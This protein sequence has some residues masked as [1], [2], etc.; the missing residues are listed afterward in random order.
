MPR[1]GKAPP[2][3]AFSGEDV[4]WQLDEWLPSLERASVWNDRTE[5]EKLLQLAGHFKGRALQEWNLMKVEEKTTFAKAIDG[6]RSRIDPANKAAAAQDF[7]H[8]TQKDSESVCPTLPGAW[9]R[10]FELPMAEML[11]LTRPE[12]CC[13]TA[14]SRRACAMNS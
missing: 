13:C 14:K 4:E 9:R 6:L 8:V 2:V 7:R 3:G 5:E 10:S 12:I 1:R 11:C